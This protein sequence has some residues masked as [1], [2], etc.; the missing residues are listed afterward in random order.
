MELQCAQISTNL[1]YS[2]ESLSTQMT[3]LHATLT[4][5]ETSTKTETE[6][7]TVTLLFASAT[8]AGP[9]AGG[10]IFYYQPALSEGAPATVYPS[11][12]SAAAI[13]TPSQVTIWVTVPETVYSTQYLSAKATSAAAS[14]SVVTTYYTTET[15]T[16]YS[17]VVATLSKEP[18][19]ATATASP[20]TS[21]RYGGWNSSSAETVQSSS[22]KTCTESLTTD[23]RLSTSLKFTASSISGNTTQHTSRDVTMGNSTTLASRTVNLSSTTIAVVGSALSLRPT[24]STCGESGNFTLGW[25][26]EPIFDPSPTDPIM[27]PPVFNP[28]HHLF[29]SNGYAFAPPP[30]APF[31]PITPPHMA[32]FL[33]N[34]SSQ[35]IGSPSAAGARP[36]ELGAGPRA[37]MSAY[38]FN[39]DSAY[40]G[41]DNGG[42]AGCLVEFVG[43]EYDATGSTQTAEKIAA[44]HSQTLSGCPGFKNCTLAR[45]SLP[46]TFTALSGLQIRATVSNAPVLFWL[47]N[48]SMGWYN[49]TCEAGLLRQMSRK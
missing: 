36:G 14:Q 40:I 48:L 43:F 6:T 41:C 18:V 3:T 26:D 20:F 28:Y 46:A 39:I 12:L 32:V 34:A 5:H 15:S 27:F 45:I 13:S 29:F 17:T 1:C 31:K 7:E 23:N 42:P 25:D 11:Q 44:T 38:W 47:D 37:Y 4:I 33:P 24:P 16:I 10:P 49:N 22:S 8:V 9:V 19:T 35:D 21:L 2:C 30:S